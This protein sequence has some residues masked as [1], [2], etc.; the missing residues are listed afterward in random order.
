VRGSVDDGGLATLP[1]SIQAY[2]L[3]NPEYQHVEVSPTFHGRDIFAPAAAHLALGRAPAEFGRRLAAIH[4]VPPFRGSASA[5]GALQGRVLH[6]DRF[7][8]IVTD[9]RAADLQTGPFLVE[10]AGQTITGP[11]VT[12]ASG[13]GLLA[14]VG[15]HGYL[16][17][18]LRDGA[19]A[20]SL[21][22]R[23]GDEVRVRP[24]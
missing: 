14:L 24:A 19:A 3:E 13:S 15:S 17:V 4:A 18:A 12:F 21:S 7:G 23:I 6:I 1:S 16:E 2:V 5:D 8:N 20:A 11:A 9:V 10:L 22:V